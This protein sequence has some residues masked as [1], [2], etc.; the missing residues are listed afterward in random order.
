MIASLEV[1]W[2]IHIFHIKPKLNF[3]RQF[4]SLFKS[5]FNFLI[6]SNFR[7]ND[8]IVDLTVW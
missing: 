1:F 3:N 8:D 2:Y 7:L 4:F 6:F 5:T